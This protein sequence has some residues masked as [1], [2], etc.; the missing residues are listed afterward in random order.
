MT[1]HGTQAGFSL[2][3]M[4]IVLSVISVIL[5]GMLPLLLERQR[6]DDLH[7]TLARMEQL[8]EALRL[9]AIQQARLPCPA[10]GAIALGSSSFGVQADNQGSCTGGAIQANQV[11][12][13]AEIASGVVPTRT[14]GLSDEMMFDGWGRRIA[15]HVTL[16]ATAAL[17][18]GSLQVQDA[19]GVARSGEAIYA[20]ISHGSSGH[21]AFTVSGAR[22]NAG[23]TNPAELE[24][25]NCDA[26]GQSAT[27]N[28]VFVQTLSNSSNTPDTRFDDIVRWV[29]LDQLNRLDFSLDCT[30]EVAMG[31]TSATADCDSGYLATGGGVACPTVTVSSQ[32]TATSWSGTCDSAP[33]TVSVICCRIQ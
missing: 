14:L 29:T 32:G 22:T 17:A 26:A 19:N 4:A 21:G 25:C 2:I 27:H 20:L 13:G 6:S 18:S 1:R 15:Y 23:I 12:A 30:R 11:N 8:Q 7:T 10:D 33:A 31:G 3:E 24:N 5:A 9:Y 28:A 16:P